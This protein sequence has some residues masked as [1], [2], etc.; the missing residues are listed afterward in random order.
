MRQAI[1]ASVAFGFDGSP[2]LRVAGKPIKLAAV[3]MSYELRATIQN[4]TLKA[5]PASFTV[6]GVK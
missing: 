5:L 6:R 4:Y 1:S 2:T 3:P